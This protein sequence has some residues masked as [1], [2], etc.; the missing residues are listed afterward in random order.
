MFFFSDNSVY[1][2]AANKLATYKFKAK[3]DGEPVTFHNLLMLLLRLRQMCC[4]PALIHAFLDR[5]D[6][7]E[8]KDVD[9]EEDPEG[10]LLLEQMG[11]MN[12]DGSAEDLD[13]KFGPGSG[14]VLTKDNPLFEDDRQSSKVS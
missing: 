6:I 5:D 7:E 13:L 1:K 2:K 12:L 4:H 3:Q 10:E 14:V 9:G 11:K 8:S